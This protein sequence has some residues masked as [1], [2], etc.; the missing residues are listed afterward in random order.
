[1]GH[2]I[3]IVGLYVYNH[4]D[5]DIRQLMILFDVGLIVGEE[6]IVADTNYLIQSYRIT[7]RS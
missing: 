6:W 1:M 2:N 4:H 3:A 5:G 7:I